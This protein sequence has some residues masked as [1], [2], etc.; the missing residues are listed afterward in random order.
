VAAFYTNNE[1]GALLARLAIHKATDKTID[2][3]C[4]S[5]TLLVSA[6][7]RKK[8]LMEAEG[9]TFTPQDHKRFLEKELTGIDIM[10]FA[11][12]LAAVHLSLQEPLYETQRV[13]LAVWGSTEPTVRPGK[14]IHTISRELRKAY[15][16]P[17]LD[18]FSNQSAAA[19]TTTRSNRTPST[20]PTC[21]SGITRRTRSWTLWRM[22]LR[23]CCLRRQ[24]RRQNEH[25]RHRHCR[26]KLR[27]SLR[28]ARQCQMEFQVRLQQRPQSRHER[29]RH[30]SQELRQR[31]RRLEP[32]MIALSSL[33][34]TNSGFVS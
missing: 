24:L 28:P 27:S 11:A 26:S 14:V 16:R 34:K 8:E 7:H 29:H 33:S 9:K 19:G 1:A 25:D 12:H 2:L 3:A 23:T 6:Y 20:R 22:I 31:K 15:A 30:C 13:R 21:G 10:P 17:K 32:L 4:G 5:G 18:M